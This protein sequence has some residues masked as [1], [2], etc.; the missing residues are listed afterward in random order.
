[1]KYFNL[2][3]IVPGWDPPAFATVQAVTRDQAKELG[4]RKV[5]AR[6]FVD[7]DSLELQYCKEDD[8]GEYHISGVIP[9]Y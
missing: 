5:A 9:F 8:S 6:Y 7:R 2:C 4:R 1:M 3:F